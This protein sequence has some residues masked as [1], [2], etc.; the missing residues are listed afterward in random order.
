MEKLLL[1]SCPTS[2]VVVGAAHHVNEDIFQAGLDLLGTKILARNGGLD[3]SLEGSGIGSADVQG[4]SENNCLL[5]PGLGAKF[6]LKLH[7][8]LAMDGPR[9]EMLAGDDFGSRTLC[10]QLSVSDIR[11]LVA[12]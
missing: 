10:Q 7:Q 5:Y 9:A 4:I 6:F 3:A 8:T 1:C 2:E 12:A 11:E